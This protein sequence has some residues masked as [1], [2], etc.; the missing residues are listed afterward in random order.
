MFMFP[1]YAKIFIR[2]NA[3]VAK[4]ERRK[5]RG[6]HWAFFRSSFDFWIFKLFAF[7][8]VWMW[9]R[10]FVRSRARATDYYREPLLLSAKYTAFNM[11]SGWSMLWLA[12]PYARL[13]FHLVASVLIVSIRLIK[14]ILPSLASVLSTSLV[15]R[16]IRRGCRP[17][18][19]S[20]NEFIRLD[21]LEIPIAI[22]MSSN[23]TPIRRSVL[24]FILALVPLTI[25]LHFSHFCPPTA[26]QSLHAPK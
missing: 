7:A 6:R 18:N 16:P 14:C 20:S 2:S 3:K 8:Y 21:G 19:L 5:E 1:E 12:V 13:P 4:K 22:R 9:R 11:F 25:S 23:P 26:M 10:S 24:G 17:E 15:S